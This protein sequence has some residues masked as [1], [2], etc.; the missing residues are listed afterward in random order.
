MRASNWTPRPSAVTDPYQLV[1]NV[2]A[3]WSDPS[4]PMTDEEARCS[5]A[6]HK[7][8]DSSAKQN[9]AHLHYLARA[10]FPVSPTGLSTFLARGPCPVLRHSRVH[11]MQ[12]AVKWLGIVTGSGHD[13]GAL[14]QLDA[15]AGG[16]CA[17]NP[18]TKVERGAITHD[19]F[20]QVLDIA[21]AA[22]K[23]ARNN[24][25]FNV[26]EVEQSMM[27]MVI[28]HGFGLRPGH[29]KTLQMSNFS[30]ENDQ[31]K[32]VDVRQK[33]RKAHF[34]AKN[35]ESHTCLQ[36]M[37]GL[38]DMV[39]NG[40]TGSVSGP[41]FIFYS[42][43]LV[44][45]WIKEAARTH[46]WE[47][48][49]WTCHCLRHGA[50]VEAFKVGGIRAA[51]DV[52]AHKSVVTTTIYARANDLRCGADADDS[53]Y[54]ELEERT[55]DI[56]DVM[57]ASGAANPSASNLHSADKTRS[58][59]GPDMYRIAR[60]QAIREKRASPSKKKSKKETKH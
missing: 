14:G 15:A 29:L 36:T 49:M 10:G 60:A 59:P 19:M 39:L 21:R 7:I 56:L 41:I 3:K 24:K 32:C 12:H 18:E 37:R 17:E 1:T 6:M 28:Q 50:A 23:R 26:H 27:G 45:E 8:L 55:Y 20:L 33:Q 57:M 42:P 11:A 13:A 53:D 46:N 58:M 35:L 4:Q 34:N 51:Q 31:R 22:T 48:L 9:V 44:T 47:K 54:E 30:V 2:V 5:L 38:V 25:A 52:C 43:A 16:Y 40:E